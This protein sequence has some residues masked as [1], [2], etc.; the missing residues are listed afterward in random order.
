LGGLLPLCSLFFVAASCGD[1]PFASRGDARVAI[2]GTAFVL[3]PGDSSVV[4]F[5]VREGT[6]TRFG[7]GLP[8]TPVFPGDGVFTTSNAAVAT[9]PDNSVIRA[10]TPGRTSLVV[11]VEGSSD[12]ASILVTGAAAIAARRVSVGGQ[13]AC[14]EG[15]GGGVRCWGSSWYG[16]TGDGTVRPLTATLS[17]VR[18]RAGEALS[19]VSAGTTHSCALAPD[20]RVMC[21]GHNALGQVQPGGPS[22]VAVPVSVSDGLRFDTVVAGGD[23]SCASTP[24]GESF[25]WGRGFHSLERLQPPTMLRGLTAGYGH[26]C[27]LDATGSA[28]CRG[29]GSYGQLGNGSF[30]SSPSFVRVSGGLVFSQIAAGTLYSCARSTD[31]AV[32]CWGRGTYGA[33]GNG[34]VADVAQPVIVALP[35]PAREVDVGTLHSC[36][37]L[38]DGE[39]WCW[40]RNFRGELGSGAPSGTTPSGTDLVSLRPTRVTTSVRFAH[41][42]VGA[43]ETTCAVAVNGFVYCWGNNLSGT[44]GTGRFDL[45]PVTSL[46]LYWT[47]VAV[48]SAPDH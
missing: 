12:S 41:L 22:V 9:V 39:I 26:T 28:W 8:R 6:E 45:D 20:H 38:V 25:C 23:H 48:R 37:L 1:D 42:S 14:L 40:G 43:D 36:A 16:E 11:T 7:G 34:S 31:G 3:S 24:D 35:R 18:V 19:L 47:P 29:D 21:W 17:P 44:V 27:G 10:I 15:A 4:G 33:L 32:A 46:P 30:L 2:A 13:H 5:A